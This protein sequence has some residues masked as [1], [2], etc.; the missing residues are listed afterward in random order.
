MFQLERLTAYYSL[1]F[2][3]Q[4]LIYFSPKFNISCFATKDVI[5]KKYFILK[6]EPERKVFKRVFLIHQDLV[7][8]KKRSQGNSSFLKIFIWK[9][10]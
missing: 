10:R 3:F 7:L 9:T 4:E 5:A 1:L 6:S 8:K 2:I